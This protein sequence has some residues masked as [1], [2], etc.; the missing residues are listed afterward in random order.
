VNRAV[1]GART[2]SALCGGRET[3]NVTRL[4]EQS[5]SLL[6]RRM[7]LNSFVESGPASD[8]VAN[9]LSGEGHPLSPN[10]QV[11]G[12]RSPSTVPLC[13][14][15]TNISFV[16]AGPCLNP[17][18]TLSLAWLPSDPFLHVVRF[19]NHPTLPSG[20]PLFY[21]SKTFLRPAS[22]P[23][24]SPVIFRSIPSCHPIPQ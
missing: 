21:H 19:L 12:P 14:R 10:V 16:P 20:V 4:A 9:G 6:D 1:T 8:G 24:M 13:L 11:R 5:L 17:D 3:Y 18:P 7:L 2:A 23:L 15:R 22:C